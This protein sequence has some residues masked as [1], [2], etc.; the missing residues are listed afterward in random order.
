[1]YRSPRPEEFRCAV[2]CPRSG[3]A[4]PD[5]V[6]GRMSSSAGPSRVCTCSVTQRGRGHRDR[7]RAVQVVALPLEDGVGQLDDLQEQVA[8]RAAARAGLSLPGELDVSPVLDPGRD[9]D[10]QGA[11]GADPA[12]PVALGA[13]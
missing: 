2:P 1:M 5:W 7:D 8:R 4:W 10:L 9:A 13:W 6:P 3:I 12:V 11:P